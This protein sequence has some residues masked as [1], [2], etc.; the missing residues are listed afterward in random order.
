MSKGLRGKREAAVEEQARVVII[1]AGIVG[2]S[3]AYHLTELGWRDI[4]VLHA[5]PSAYSSLVELSN[6]TAGCL[7]ERGDQRPYEK[8]TFARF[9]VKP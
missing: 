2:C 6:D 4:V 3:T 7:Y 9:G 5:G 8:I 1:G